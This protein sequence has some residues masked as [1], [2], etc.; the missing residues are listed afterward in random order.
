MEAKKEIIKEKRKE[1][2]DEKVSGASGGKKVEHYCGNCGELMEF[3]YKQDYS[4]PM[5]YICH[6]CGEIEAFKK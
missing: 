3:A 5:V 1:L 4:Y 2:S 6:V